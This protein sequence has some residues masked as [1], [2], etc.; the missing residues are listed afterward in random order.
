MVASKHQW[1]WYAEDMQANQAESRRGGRNTLAFMSAPFLFTKSNSGINAVS[2]MFK[3]LDL[4]EKGEVS[5]V[6][7]F[8][9]KRFT[10]E[11][12]DSDTVMT[13]EAFA[14]IW[15]NFYFEQATY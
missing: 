13:A 6:P 5:N 11:S 14:D 9:F 10:Q 12:V 1:K 4:E 15:L 8:G 2:A 3:Q 7:I